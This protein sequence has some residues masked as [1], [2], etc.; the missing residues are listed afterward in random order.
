MTNLK[1]NSMI[2][3]NS[4]DDKMILI[5]QTNKT[6]TSMGKGIRNRINS[7]LRSVERFRLLIPRWAIVLERVS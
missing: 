4:L 1:T 5:F 7:Y 3:Q 2:G 6:R